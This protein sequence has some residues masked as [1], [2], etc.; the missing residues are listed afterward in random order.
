MAENGMNFIGLWFF[1][2]KD[3]T[4]NDEKEAET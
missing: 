2:K 1:T 4:N 3:K